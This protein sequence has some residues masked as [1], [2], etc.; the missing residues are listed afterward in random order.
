MQEDFLFPYQQGKD[1]VETL[2]QAGGWSAVDQAYLNP[3]LSSE[4]IL[5]PDRYPADMP[6][7]VDLT[8]QPADLG[9]GWD[10]IDRGVMGEWYT[11]LVLFSG[12]DPNGRINRSQALDAAAGWEGDAY[13]VFYNASLNQTVMVLLTEWEDEAEAVEFTQAFQK[14]ASLRFGQASGGTPDENLWDT[15]QGI[16]VLNLQDTTTAWVLAPSADLAAQIWQSL[17]KP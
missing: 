9:V 17:T 5:H 6:T 12:L 4:Q 11:A 14:Y 1:F 2:Y 3:P 7:P 15:E 16:H 13:A 8:L 10:E